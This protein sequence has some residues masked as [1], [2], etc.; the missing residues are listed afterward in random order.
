[1]SELKIAIVGASGRMGRML[2]EAV[3]KDGQAKLISAIDLPETSAI[4]KDA[5]VVK[6]SETA[7]F[8]KAARTRQFARE[9]K[10][11]TLP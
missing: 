1:M 3:L 4:G 9:P 8:I 11:R 7:A 10:V 5:G 2:I 6:A